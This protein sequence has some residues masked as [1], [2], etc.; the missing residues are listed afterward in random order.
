MSA[1]TEDRLRKKYTICKESGCWEW[2][3]AVQSNG[4]GRVWYNGKVQYAHRVMYERNVGTIKEG[5]DLD[6]LCRNRKCVNPDHLE[7]VTRSENLKRGETG[8][9]IAEPLRKKTHCP[10]GHPYSGD[11]LRLYGGRRHCRACA[12]NRHNHSKNGGE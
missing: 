5:M 3:A 7:Q 1:S 11:N 8:E 6:H 9:N 4:Y 10:K 12:R 2:T